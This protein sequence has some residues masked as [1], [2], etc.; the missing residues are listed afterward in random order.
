MPP[1]P[2]LLKL[3]Q[4]EKAKVRWIHDPVEAVKAPRR[5][6]HVWASMG[7]K[8][9][10]ERS[11]SSWPFQVNAKLLKHA[12]PN[13]IVLHCLPPNAAARSLMSDGGPHSASSIRP[14]T[15]AHQKAIMAQ[16]IAGADKYQEGVGLSAHFSIRIVLAA[17]SHRRLSRFSPKILSQPTSRAHRPISIHKANL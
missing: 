13:H 9:K 2:R 10:F 16:L 11:R 4:D 12:A 15:A 5:L 8:D 6:Y 3:A 1:Q 17:F 14:K 7:Q